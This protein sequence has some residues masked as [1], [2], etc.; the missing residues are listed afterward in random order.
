MLKRNYFF[1]IP[2]LVVMALVFGVSEGVDAKGWPRCDLIETHNQG[3]GI[4]AHFEFIITNTNTGE[5]EDLE[6][7]GG[8]L[9]ITVEEEDPIILEDVE[10]G[11]LDQDS[12]PDGLQAD[13]LKGNVFGISH[14]DDI[15]G[16]IVQCYRLD[17][18]SVFAVC[19]KIVSVHNFIDNEDGTYSADV[20]LMLVAK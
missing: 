17:T 1:L 5:R 20:I 4:R 18:G 6:V 15:W 2:I 7:V 14:T 8:C 9:N 3:P 10:W 16:L 19:L 12:P 13:E 11:A